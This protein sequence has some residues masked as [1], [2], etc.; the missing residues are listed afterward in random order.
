[1]DEKRIWLRCRASRGQFRDECAVSGRDYSGEEF[2]LFVASPRVF[3]LAALGESETDAFVEVDVID[4]E[5]DFVL[6]RLPDQTFGNGRTI[7][8]CNSELER[9]PD[10]QEA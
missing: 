2:S 5:G 4:R 8:V 3:P 7:T 1:M 10:R 9:S 6:V